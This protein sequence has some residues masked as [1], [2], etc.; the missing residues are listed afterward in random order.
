MSDFLQSLRSHE[1]NT[2]PGIKTSD[3]ASPV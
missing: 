3:I 1:T 2:K